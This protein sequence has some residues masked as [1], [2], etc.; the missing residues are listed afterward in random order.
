MSGHSSRAY[1]LHSRYRCTSPTIGSPTIL[2]SMSSC[3]SWML[4]FIIFVFIVILRKFLQWK[5]SP[6]WSIAGPI[7]NFGFSDWFTGVFT[8]V[9][10]E[11]FMAPHQRWLKEL[12]DAGVETPLLHYTGLF[13]RHFIMVLDADEVKRVVTAPAQTDPP[14]FPKGL[15]YLQN[16]LG[17]GLVTLEGSQW[18]R[19]RRIIQPAFSNHFLQK[20]L[21][22]IIPDLVERMSCSW[23]ANPNVDIDISGHM[24]AL[25]LDIIGKVAFSHEFLA[26]ESVEKWSKGGSCDIELND[27]LIKSFYSSLTPS[28]IRMILVNMRLTFLE[29]YILRDKYN[30]KVILDC[31]VK[32]V[33]EKA[34][35]K[36]KRHQK[37]ASNG[38]DADDGE[39]KCLL[40]E[41]FDAMD[42]RHNTLSL[43]E[44]QG[45]TKTFLIAG[46]ETTAT[47][48]TW[49][50]YC[51]I[52]YPH[53]LELAR[54]DVSMHAPKEGKIGIE[55]TEKMTYLEAF[56]NE[57]LRL[58]PPV[59]MVVRSTS[60]HINIRGE[61]IPPGT[62]VVIPI[63]LLH[64]DPKYW[65]DPLEFK[66]ERWLKTSEKDPLFHH[67][68]F[69][70]FSAGGR[71]CI[72]Q[73]FAMFEAKLILAP[74]IRDF[75]FELSPSLDG[76][77]IKLSCFI[78]IKCSPPMLVRVTPR[79]R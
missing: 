21:D 30:A 64:R 9:E 11:P 76:V 59:G 39:V 1:L 71:N 61:L 62:R 48:S 7:K 60:R 20:S 18:H 70:P 25:T 69:L 8:T 54:K 55:S 43:Q 74:L 17:N 16:V 47:L 46:H 29:K 72:G 40:E 10:K 57:V 2:S 13:G 23:R 14:L 45:E 53:A 26:L 36:Y 38:V 22:T 28:I 49:F 77:D 79:S 58:H 63:W 32:S 34:Q 41:M 68:A 33:V 65:T 19:H 67:F 51:A 12:H 35:L 52:K 73:R 3:L 27:P 42:S 44:L 75:D 31:A 5:Y 78:T 66:P 4:A 50:I 6:L 56:I 37:Y 15:A 24:S